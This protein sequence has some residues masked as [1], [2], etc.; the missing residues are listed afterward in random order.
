LLAVAGAGDVSFAQRW[1]Q[2]PWISLSAGYEN[3]RILERGPE[4][5]TVPGGNFFDIIPGFLLSRTIGSRTRLNLDGQ[6]T[7]EQFSNDEGRSLFGAAVNAELR[8]RVRSTWRWRLTVGG[9]YFADS[10]QESVNRYHVGAETAFGPSGRRGYLELLLGAQGRRYHNLIA[11]DE[12]GIPGTYTE[13]GASLGA[14]GAIRPTGRLVLTGL[15]VGQST[16]ARDPIYDATSLLAQAGVRVA[17]AGPVWVFVSAMSQDRTFTERTSGED[18]DS[19]RQLGAG[20]EFPLSRNFDLEARY[21]AARY[22]DTLGEEDDIYRFSVGVTWW[23][24]GRGTRS[25]PDVLPAEIMEETEQEIIRAGDPHL[26]RL[27]A[28]EAVAVS[29]VAD[30]NGWDPDSQPLVRAGGGWWEARVALPQGSHQYA[31][32]VDGDLVTPPE[33]DTTVDDGFGGRN[34]LLYVEPERP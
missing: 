31:Y 27:R 7:L 30:F 14:T 29:L 13:L 25:L 2:Y 3:D 17:V 9:N 21:A 22:T 32:W 18:T 34:G 26:F 15:V 23:P 20:V 10:I 24:G 16:D 28:P 1:E 11:L 33:A 12:S 6:L 19:Y 4:V 8:R 5:Y